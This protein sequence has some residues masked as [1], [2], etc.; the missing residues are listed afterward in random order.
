MKFSIR[1][2]KGLQEL[3]NIEGVRESIPD[4]KVEELQKIID[5]EQFLER[6]LGVRVHIFEVKQ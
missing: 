6:I 4:L 3:A 5:T 2:T 1:I